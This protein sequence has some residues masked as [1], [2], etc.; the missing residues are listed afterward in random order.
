MSTQLKILCLGGDGIGPEVVNAGLEVLHA[1]AHTEDMHI[2]LEEDLLDGAS[3]DVRGIFCRDQVVDKAKA[4]DAV[5]VGSVGGPKWDNFKIG[6]IAQVARLISA[7]SPTVR[8]YS[9]AS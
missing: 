1:V 5:L 9:P 6:L 8:A 7:V 2:V 3:W 4:Q